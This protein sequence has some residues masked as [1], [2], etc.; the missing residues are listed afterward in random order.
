MVFFGSIIPSDA[1]IQ[2]V[3]EN[4]SGSLKNKVIEFMRMIPEWMNQRGIFLH[5]PIDQFFGEYMQLDTLTS[6]E[7]KTA[8]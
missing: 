5:R 1:V 7:K 6:P 2:L 8:L 3:N 4:L